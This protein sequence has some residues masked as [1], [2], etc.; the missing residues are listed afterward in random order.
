AIRREDHDPFKPDEP[1]EKSA[2][3]ATA[4][5]Y[6]VKHGRPMAEVDAMPAARALV[7]YLNEYARERRDEVFK[8]ANL[9]FLQAQPFFAAA[10]ARH[11]A[12]AT[13]AEMFAELRRA[14]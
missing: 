6:L 1:A 10:D 14:G 4:R 11:R 2:E 8:A 5:E 9:P 3:L 12:A 7:L 13:E